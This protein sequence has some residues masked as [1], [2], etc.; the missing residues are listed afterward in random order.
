M[1][2]IISFISYVAAPS[3]ED[4]EKNDDNSELVVDRE[5]ENAVD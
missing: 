2:L 3:Y 1:T 4:E 5:K